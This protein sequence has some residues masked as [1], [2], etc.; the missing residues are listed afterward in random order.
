M[1]Q[2]QYQTLPAVWAGEYLIEHSF[3][4]LFHYLTLMQR[5]SAKGVRTGSEWLNWE[6]ENVITEK[7]KLYLLWLQNKDRR[8]YESFFVRKEINKGS[9]TDS[10]ERGG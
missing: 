2:L 3:Q 10:S 6:F 9:G 7:R 1:F 4:S 8:T 5:I